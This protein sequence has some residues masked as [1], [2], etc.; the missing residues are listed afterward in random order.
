LPLQKKKRDDGHCVF[1]DDQCIPY[2]KQWDYLAHRFLLSEQDLDRVLDA[3]GKQTFE[4]S[5]SGDMDDAKQL[6]RADAPKR[7]KK[8]V[9]KDIVLTLKGQVAI[10][11]SVLSE[12]E[13]LLLKKRGVITNPKYFQAQ[14]MR[15]ST[16]KIPKYIFCGD[17]DDQFMYLPRGLYSEVITTL[18]AWGYSPQIDDKRNSNEPLLLN[19][20]GTLFDHQSS[21][22]DRLVREDNAVLVAPTGTGKTIIGIALIARRNVRTLILVHRS[23]LI[24][25]WI[26]ALC[27]FLPEIEKKHIGVLGNGRK[28]LK[29]AIDIG[30]LQTVAKCEDIESLTEGYDFVIIDECHRVPTVTFEPVLKA[31]KARYVLGLT[32]T[33]IRKD[34]FEAII[35]MQCGVIAHT[36]GD[37]N[38]QN[39]IR[40]VHFRT[41]AL[42]DITGNIAIQ[43]LWEIITESQERN[44]QIVTD[45]KDLLS[46][47][48]S[49]VVLSD[50]TEHLDNLESMLS[51]Q[52]DCVKLKLRGSMGKKE[53]RGVFETIRS[54]EQEHEPYCLFATG[55]LIGEGFDLPE[56]DTMLITM[57]ISFKGRL[58]QYV[59]R[60][61]RL[62]TGTKE[63]L[64][65]DYVD[66]CS[67][68]TISMFKKRL[69]AY[70]KLEYTPVYNPQD[71]IARWL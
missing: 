23:T 57:P 46:S 59:G 1:V 13:V 42:P 38:L 8:R 71:V 12:R 18:Q 24:D 22:V 17:N 7:T 45:I 28:K 63:I 15:F 54:C 9:K 36:I 31:M 66:T 14:K 2:A 55:S 48:R 27:S 69:A 40:K 64:V 62:G 61:H 70:K 20:S 25:Q 39:Q 16:W 37:I 35:F 6:F 32:A 58:T 49:P 41:T 19:F 51:E 65:Y 26:S 47:G 56:L 30:M 29:G 44:E 34:R 5:S 67:A 50:R 53:R 4:L 60:L 33:P 43:T 68:I 3:F 52:K 10:P 11:L 21:A